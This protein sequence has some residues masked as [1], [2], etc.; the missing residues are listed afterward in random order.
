MNNIMGRRIKERRELFGYTLEQ[1][2]A[3][4]VPLLKIKKAS[5][6]RIYW[7]FRGLINAAGEQ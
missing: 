3:P 5:E 4:F 2:T 6:A 7:T 1:V